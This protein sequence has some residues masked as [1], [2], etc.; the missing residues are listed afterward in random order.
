MVP[1]RLVEIHAIEKRCVITRQ[2]LV[3]DNEDLRILIRPLEH[4]T[5]VCLAFR[6]K[7]EFGNQRTIH[8]IADIFRVDRRSPFGWQQPVERALVLG[9]GFAVYSDEERL[10]TE[11]QNLLLEVPSYKRRDLIDPIV[12]GEE[13]AQSHRTVENLVEFIDVGD[14]L[15]F[16]QGEKLPV[17]PLRGHRHLARRH[18]V[19]DR[20]RRLVLDRLGDGV[21]VEVAQFV[22]GTEDLKSALALSRLV[23][24]RA[25]E[26]DDRRIGQSRH[27]VRAQIP[28]DRAVRLVDE[29][30]DVVAGIGVLLDALEL[31]DHGEN[32]AALVGSKQIPEFALGVRTPDWNILLLHLAEQPLDP[33]LELSFKLRPVHDHDDRRRAEPVLA[34]QDQARGSE[35]RK[36]FAGTLR[37]PD[38]PATSRR[39]L[40]TL[41]D[42]V[43]RAALMLPEHRLSGFTVFDVEEDPVSQRAQKIGRLEERLDGEPIALLWL[44]LPAG[45][46]PARCVPGNA[47]PVFDQVRDIEELRRGYQLRGLDLVAS[48]LRDGPLDGIGILG[49]LVL[50]DG[51]RHTVDHE[52][53]I[54]PVTLAG[55]RLQLPLPGNVID[56]GA[57]RLEIDEPDATMTLLGLVVPLPFAVQPGE[58]LAVALDG[59]WDRFDP[60][61]DGADGGVRHPEIEPPKRSFELT[62]EHHPGLATALVHRDFRRE[63]NPADLRRVAN[64]GELHRGGLA[65]LEIGHDAPLP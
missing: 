55:R 58:H 52:H 57:R 40:A 10:V 27:Q 35:Q 15:D 16:G 48:Q 37:M 63:R 17:E 56:V 2:Q 14:T 18:R 4:E 12:G 21:L 33:A 41:D 64:H 8:N 49:V 19:A 46:V 13:G 1:H 47:V 3:G 61:D 29:H 62:S 39:L 30:V 7:L 42:A 26:S 53:H 65:N 28:G 51:N 36:G 54:R 23:D 59:R 6:G 5:H 11:R 20:Q 25:G 22:V 44:F 24:R 32:Q 50:H 60:L 38:Q 34:L 43:D 45:H 31:M 9:A